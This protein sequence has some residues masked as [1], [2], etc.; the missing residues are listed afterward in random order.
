MA[1]ASALCET[2]PNNH[3][4]AWPHLFRRIRGAQRRPANTRPI[5]P[6]QARISEPSGTQLPNYL[7][8]NTL[9]D[10]LSSSSS[11]ESVLGAARFFPFFPFFPLVGSWII[12][13]LDSGGFCVGLE[14]S[15]KLPS[16]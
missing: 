6:V 14:V 10:A 12:E 13:S 2:Y 11:S 5:M 3:A 7:E 9:I 8:P 4:R 15:Y 1:N 16:I